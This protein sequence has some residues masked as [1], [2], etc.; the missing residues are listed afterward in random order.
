M[1][2][3]LKN[4]IVLLSA[5]QQKYKMS[6]LFI[7]GSIFS[8]FSVASFL[9]WDWC[10]SKI[11]GLRVQVLSS[12]HKNGGIYHVYCNF[13]LGFMRPIAVIFGIMRDGS[14]LT[15]SLASFNCFSLKTYF[16]MTPTLYQKR[17]KTNLILSKSSKFRVVRFLRLCS[18]LDLTSM[19]YKYF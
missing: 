18:N 8:L 3:I 9:V 12:L 19:W 4:K 6:L 11:G 7:N 2:F 15:H 1:W 17:F 16:R 14:L 13:S 5:S 10:Y